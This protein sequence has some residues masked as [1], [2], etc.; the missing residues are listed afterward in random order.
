[1]AIVGIDYLEGLKKSGIKLAVTNGCFDLLHQGHIDYLKRARL[2]GDILV[3]AVNSDESVKRLKG[4]SR[5]IIPLSARIAM[6]NALWFVDYVV[7]FDEDTP[8]ELYSRIRPDVLVK[9]G[10]YAG[11][12]IAG[13]EYAG[14]VELVHL[15]AGWSTTWIIE[16][17]KNA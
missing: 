11:K 16:R 8:E 9:G 5:P 1:M 4:E 17:I 6:L 7:P 2:Y 12:K 10:D 14:R 15:S 3:V 13:A